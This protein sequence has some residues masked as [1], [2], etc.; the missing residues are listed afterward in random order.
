MRHN[1]D[2]G[3][4]TEFMQRR[5]MPVDRFE[6]DLRWR[7]LHIVMRWCVEGAA[8]ADAEVD[9]RRLDQRLDRGLDQARLRRRR[10][11]REIFR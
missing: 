7:H 6:I 4:M 1:P 5:A 10:S 11:D 8:A 9:A 3:I 2:H